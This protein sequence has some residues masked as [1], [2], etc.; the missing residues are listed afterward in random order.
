MPAR[1]DHEK[2]VAAARDD[3]AVFDR[4][5]AL[6]RWLQNYLSPAATIPESEWCVV[7]KEAKG[8][9]VERGTIDSD[10][11]YQ[12]AYA[13]AHAPAPPVMEIR[14]PKPEPVPP[15]FNVPKPR[16]VDSYEQLIADR[17]DSSI[18]DL[19]LQAFQ[20]AAP[21]TKP[22][23]V[24]LTATMIG[25]MQRQAERL[26]RPSLDKLCMKVDADW[27]NDRYTFRSE[28]MHRYAGAYLRSPSMVVSMDL[29]SG[30][31]Q[32]TVTELKRPPPETSVRNK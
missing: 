6:E 28:W 14:P 1:Q 12:T 17:L 27:D 4:R 16:N 30:P 32:T 11:P 13:D 26:M 7:T 24:G 2:I 3:M 18:R 5:Q 31:D 9:K 8:W 25:E 21:V 20:Y 23:S 22:E 19:Y 10:V 15:R 29:A